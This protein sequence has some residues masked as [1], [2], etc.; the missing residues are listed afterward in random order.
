MMGSFEGGLRQI[1]SPGD[2]PGEFS[3]QKLLC[4]RAGNVASKM[5]L[6]DLCSYGAAHMLLGTA[7]VA[8]F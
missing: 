2:F 5:P 4:P 3:S 1:K 8:Q 6:E 7:S